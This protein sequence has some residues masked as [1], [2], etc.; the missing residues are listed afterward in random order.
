MVA[1]RIAEN[2]WGLNDEIRTK[3]YRAIFLPTLLY[4]APVWSEALCKG[5]MGNR[6]KLARVQRN[7]LIW[8][9]RLYG[10]TSFDNVLVVAD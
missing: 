5:G 2:T 1:K 10:T 3:L 8:C 7:V 9:K 4:A 6:L